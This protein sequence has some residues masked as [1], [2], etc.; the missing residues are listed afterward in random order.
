VDDTKRAE[1]PAIAGINDSLA[2]A[3]R[4]QLAAALRANR[5]MARGLEAVGREIADYTQASLETA[6]ATATALLSVRTFAD[7]VRLSADFAKA[8]VEDLAMRSARLSE[9]GVKLTEEAFT[10]TS[11]GGSNATAVPK[12]RSRAA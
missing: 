11:E 8:N 4:D 12:S 10:S 6:A 2:D 5:A 7:L 1:S 9:V 3:T